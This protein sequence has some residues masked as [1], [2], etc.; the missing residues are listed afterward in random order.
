MKTFLTMIAL[1]LATPAIAQTAPA[2]PHSGHAQ[3]TAPAAPCTPEHAAMGHCTLEA[4]P[5][6]H[7]HADHDMQG[8]CCEKGADDKMA[9]CEKAK[10]AGKKMDCCDK[11][12][13][14]AAPQA[15]HNGH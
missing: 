11:K 5:A 6:A 10:A 3:Q 15:G 12:G 8:E 14:T 4:A 9:C 2:N 13:A 7:P 1:A